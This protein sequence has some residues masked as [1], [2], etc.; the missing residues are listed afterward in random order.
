[1][2]LKKDSRFFVQLGFTD[3]RKQ[4]NGPSA[5]VQEKRLEGPFDGSYYVLCGKTRK[6]VKILYWDSTGFCLWLKRLEKDSF[7]GLRKAL[8][9]TRLPGIESG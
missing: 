9:L 2:V 3:M 8:T 4:I 7:P 1:M 5:L 6:V